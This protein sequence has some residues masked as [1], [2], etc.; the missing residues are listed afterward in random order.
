MSP[1]TSNKPSAFEKY[2]S[3]RKAAD[4][5]FAKVLEAEF[6]RLKGE[7]EKIALNPRTRISPEIDFD[8]AF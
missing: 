6:E 1:P 2:V 4:P 5:E 7:Q 8:A 3:E